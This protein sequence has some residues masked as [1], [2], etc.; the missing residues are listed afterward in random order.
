MIVSLE[1]L[2]TY[3]TR[4]DGSGLSGERFVRITH[5]QNEEV[6]NGYR[7]PRVPQSAGGANVPLPGNEGRLLEISSETWRA[8][9]ARHLPCSS[10]A[11]MIA[12]QTAYPPTFPPTL[13]ST[14]SPYY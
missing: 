1:G 6:L 11:W 2:H 9:R 14:T 5:A 8:L 3:I 7:L 12:E 10:S 13:R 4:A